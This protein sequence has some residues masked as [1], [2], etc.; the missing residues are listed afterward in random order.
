M[1]LTKCCVVFNAYVPNELLQRKKTHLFIQMPID[2][3]YMC[4]HA[5]ARFV[6]NTLQPMTLQNYM[7][8]HANPMRAMKN[9]NYSILMHV[10]LEA[11]QNRGF[12]H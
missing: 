1:H 8:T 11:I 3:K 5:I 12:V 4:T 10:V 9:A 6:E 7:Q 2:V